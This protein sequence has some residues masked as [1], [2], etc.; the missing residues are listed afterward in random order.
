MPS[1]TRG[2]ATPLF[3]VGQALIVGETVYLVRANGVS[4]D[5]KAADE[6]FTAFQRFH[7]PEDFEGIGIGLA[8]VQLIIF[9]SNRSASL[10]FDG[11]PCSP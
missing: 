3:E 11:R 8:T 5:M 9:C 7:R 2:R 6:L 4:F 10:R 1:N